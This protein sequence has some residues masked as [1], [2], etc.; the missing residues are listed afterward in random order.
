MESSETLAQ[1]LGPTP[2]CDADNAKIKAKVRDLADGKDPSEAARSIFYFV[3]DQISLGSYFADVPASR[4]LD[5]GTGDCMAKTNLQMALL[6]AAGIPCRCHLVQ[7]PKEVNRA[8]IPPFFFDRMPELIVHPW[9]ECYLEGR[10]LACDCVFDEAFHRAMVKAG[11]TTEADMPSIDW[12]GTSDV[13][14]GKRHL[15]A[16]LGTFP[17]WDEGLKEARKRG[18]VL[19]STRVN[20]V[21]GPIM[22]S[23]INRRVGNIRKSAT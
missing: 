6:R 13:I 4:T 21:L 2:L 15:K 1:F 17:S 9:C 11:H 22:F 19:T 18:T 20:R 14:F 7:L 12:D 23:M 16:D 8:W 10:W 5:H 3:R